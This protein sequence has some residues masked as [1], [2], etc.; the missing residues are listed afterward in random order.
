MEVHIS[1]VGQGDFR[2]V[3]ITPEKA[4]SVPVM[5]MFQDQ[6]FRAKVNLITVDEAHLVDEWCVKCQ[7]Q[8]FNT[9][10]NSVGEVNFVQHMGRG[11]K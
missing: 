6:A 9:A 5:D 1:K 4:K 10:L 11:A 8:I 7:I 2:W 3:F